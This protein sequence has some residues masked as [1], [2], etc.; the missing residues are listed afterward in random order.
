MP[1]SEPFGG[2]PMFRRFAVAVALVVC[3]LTNLHAE[4]AMSRERLLLRVTAPDPEGMLPGLYRL[5][6]DFAG[7]DT[8][9]KAVDLLGDTG[10]VGF[11]RNLGFDVEVVRDVSATADSFEALS[12]YLSP[13]EVAQRLDQYVAT[14]PTLARKE[15]Y[16]T[17]VEGRSVWAIKISDNVTVDEDEPAILIVAQ[18]H[19]REVMTPEIAMDAIDFLLTRYA[20]DPQVKAWVD[21]TEIWVLPNHNP[22]GSNYVFTSDSNWRKNRRNNGSGIFGVDPNRNYPFRWNACSGSSGDPNSETY[23]GPSAASEPETFQG[24]V[25]LARRERPVMALSYH[26]YSE[27]VLMPYGCTGSHTSERET[28]RRIAS[29]MATRLV[30]DTGTSWYQPGAPWEILYAVDGASDDWFY[31]ELGTY[32]VTI[33]ANTSSQGFQPDYAT[34]RTSTVL[35]NRPG[36][37]YLLERLDGPG[38]RGHVTNACTGAPLAANVSLDEVVFSGGETART[39][40]PQHGRYQFLTVPGPY[41]LRASLPGFRPQAWPTEVG[42]KAFDRDLRLVPTGSRGLAVRSL[43][44]LDA[45]ADNDGQADPGETVQIGIRLVATGEALTGVQATLASSDPWVTVTQANAAYGPLASDAEAE[46]TF[47]VAISPDAPDGH[48]AS[49][50]VTFA[51]NEGVCAASEPVT[52]R[53]TTG[54]PI[55]PFVAQSLDANPGWTIANLGTGGWQFGVPTVVGPTAGHTGNNVYATNLSG[56]Y[57]GSGDF[58]L[59]TTPFDLRGLRGAELRF[60]RWLKNEPG[61]DI[62]TV[63]ASID[64]GASWTEVWKGFH[65]GEGWQEERVDLSAFADQ[66]DDVRFRFKLTSDVGTEEAGFYVDDVAVCGEAVPTAGGKL[67]YLSHAATEIGPSGSNGN[68]AIDAGETAIVSVQVRSNR[69]VV[70]TGVEAFLSTNEPGVTVRNGWTALADVPAAGTAGSLA[71]HFTVTFDPSTCRKAVPFTLDLRWDGGRS[72]SSFT[73][74]VGASATTVVLDDDFE[75]DRGWTAGGNASNGAWVREDPYGVTAGGLPIQPEDDTT[76]APGVLAW[77]TGNPRPKG[78]FNPSSG[79]VDGGTAWLQS[80][81]FDGDGAS[82]LEL[83]L[84]R[85]F[86]RKNPS[87]SDQS[88]FRLRV[89]SDNGTTWRDLESLTADAA[90]WSPVSLDLVTFGGTSSQM[91]LRVEVNEILTF[92]DTILEGLIDDVHLE[93]TRRECAPYTPAAATAPNGVG[94]TVTASRDGDHVRLLWSAPPVDAGHGAA[95]GY[96]VYRSLAPSGGFAVA[97]LPTS[98]A[99]ILADEAVT[100]GS[101]YYLVAAENNGGVSSD[102]P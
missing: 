85:W 20:T 42:P 89:S 66:A 30:G 25:E 93:R 17:T 73:V 65:W 90:T 18:H 24:I 63:E 29:D 50:T 11:L 62:A 52:L 57:G 79:D 7:F 1:L 19:A 33:E 71:P 87:S 77:V 12:D 28:F 91:R 51:A 102:A 6:L 22:D 72:L 98:N 27:L 55:C 56:N 44:V 67:T 70:S 10:T 34:W 59:T 97:A 84:K 4:P 40:T 49:L 15:V 88:T 35:R 95:T 37:R 54:Y 78:N 5:D 53:I 68:G 43:R 16:A 36:W 94:S 2:T 83:D 60:W 61:Y 100:P 41:T 26:T 99:A 47:T 23:R 81:V 86:T 74:P 48:V 39:A 13:S 9:T 96:R 101:A 46:G 92:G 82:R 80:P 64:G 32:S 21:G 14:Y 75:V 8:K 76:A 3:A 45:A 38:V 58:R 69:D 31:G